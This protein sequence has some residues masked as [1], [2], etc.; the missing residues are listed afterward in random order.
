MKPTIEISWVVFHPASNHDT[1]WYRLFLVEIQPGLEERAKYEIY[2]LRSLG[3]VF[4]SKKKKLPINSEYLR[5]T[6]SQSGKMFSDIYGNIE[7]SSYFVQVIIEKLYF[8]MKKREK[9]AVL[10]KYIKDIIVNCFTWFNNHVNSSELI[11]NGQSFLE[12]ILPLS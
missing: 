8:P 12:S 11:T 6:D 5:N 4:I 2:E 10:N 1:L 9:Y 3:D 7:G